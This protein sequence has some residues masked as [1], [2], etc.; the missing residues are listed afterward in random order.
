MM[1]LPVGFTEHDLNILD[2]NKYPHTIERT[3]QFERSIM[4]I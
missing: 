2:P 1:V 3:A 4:I